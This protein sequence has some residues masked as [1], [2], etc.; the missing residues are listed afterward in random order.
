MKIPGGQKVALINTKT[1]KQRGVMVA[2]PS[3][4]GVPMKECTR[5]IKGAI[6]YTA[7]Q[8]YG[9]AY[10]DVEGANI[11]RNRNTAVENAV[12]AKVHWLLF[13]DD[14]MVFEPDAI[15][16]LLDRDLDIVGGLC[17]RKVYPFEPVVGVICDD[18][19]YR[20]L[21]NITE[22]LG[23]VLNCDGTGTAFLL[24]KMSVF[25]KLE[26]P[27]FAMPPKD[28]GVLGEDLYFCR[29]AVEAGFKIHVD[30]SVHVGHLGLYPYTIGDSIRVLEE[31]ARNQG[32]DDS[33]KGTRPVSS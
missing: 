4:R 10:T 32:A 23:A 29:K 16:K 26:K 33:T 13:V 7:E 6:K 25:D 1:P 2:V 19:K 31:E 20:L 3:H 15:C 11:S 17:V 27:Y 9:V 12:K 30:S 8:G 24:I 21:R 28:D 18:G 22:N 5:S 14:D